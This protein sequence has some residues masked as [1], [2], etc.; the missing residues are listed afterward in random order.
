MPRKLHS[1]KFYYNE[2]C[3][4]LHLMFFLLLC[5]WSNN[6]I[7]C[8]QLSKRQHELSNIN[9]I[10]I[11]KKKKLEYTIKTVLNCLSQKKFNSEF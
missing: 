1:V 9:N 4:C 11:K 3:V 5:F 10:F 6:I 7:L 2:M 8:F